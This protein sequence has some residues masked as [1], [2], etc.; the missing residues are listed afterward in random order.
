MTILPFHPMRSSPSKPWQLCSVSTLLFSSQSNRNYSSY[1]QH[2]GDSSETQKVMPS[3]SNGA[4]ETFDFPPWVWISLRSK[5]LDLY[6]LP[7]DFS[8]DMNLLLKFFLC[9]SVRERERES[10]LS[11]FAYLFL[12]HHPGWIRNFNNTFLRFVFTFLLS[13]SPALDSGSLV[14]ILWFEVADFGCCNSI[15]WEVSPIIDRSFGCLSQARKSP[16]EIFLQ[17]I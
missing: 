17:S 13:V 7:F 15:D 10:P 6:H 2:K 8:R 9:C 11:Y 1:I 16:N 3:S 4:K 12:H 14:M 5:N